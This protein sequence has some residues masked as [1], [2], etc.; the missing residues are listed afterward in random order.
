MKYDLTK[1]LIAI[2][3]VLALYLLYLKNKTKSE[4]FRFKCANNNPACCAPTAVSANCSPANT[5]KATSSLNRSL[6]TGE[7]FRFRRNIGKYGCMGGKCGKSDK[8]MPFERAMN[9]RPK[10]LPKE[11]FGF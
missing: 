2:A 1:I 3:V 11:G 5:G 4:M 7:P 9:S 6:L 8:G 10:A